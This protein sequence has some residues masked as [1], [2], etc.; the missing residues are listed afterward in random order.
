[1]TLTRPRTIALALGLLVVVT[2][3]YLVLASTR[4]SPFMAVHSV[5]EAR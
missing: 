5:A 1:M 3:G 2:L 4:S